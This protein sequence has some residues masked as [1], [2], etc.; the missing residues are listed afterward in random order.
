M[1]TKSR[2]KLGIETRPTIVRLVGRHHCISS[3]SP[4]AVRTVKIADAFE[5]GGGLT[6]NCLPAIVPFKHLAWRALLPAIPPSQHSQS[7]PWG[8]CADWLSRVL[9]RYA[10][11][12]CLRQGAYTIRRTDGSGE[13]RGL[14][15]LPTSL[16]RGE[17]S[18]R[19]TSSVRV[20][21]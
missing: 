4:L 12:R 21:C 14:A 13:G 17:P 1:P 19:N 5:M 7:R 6:A 8:K 11:L 10:S 9:A 18:C 3:T 2:A 20:A 15:T 16:T